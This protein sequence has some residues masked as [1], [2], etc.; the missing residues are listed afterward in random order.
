MK[1]SGFTLIEL[2]VVIAIIAILAAI[3]FP[4]FARAR[5]KARQASCTSNMKQLALGMLMYMQDYDE[6]APSVLCGRYPG[7]P[8]A[9]PQDACCVERNIWAWVVQP[10]VK[11]RQ[12]MQCPSANDTDFTRPATPY[13]PAGPVHYKFKHAIAAQNGVKLSA[14]GWPAQQIMFNEYRAWHSSIECGCRVPPNVSAQYLVAFWDGHV[15]VVRVGDTLMVKPPN[16][17]HWD[18]HWFKIVGNAAGAWTADPSIGA[19]F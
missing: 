13:G 3:L 17:T 14:F 16:P 9:Y 18:P 4:V 19:D 5:E 10:Y 2:L 15:K 11:N 12:I 7:G 1:R 6:R 8:T